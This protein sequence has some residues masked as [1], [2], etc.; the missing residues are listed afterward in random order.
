MDL[1]GTPIYTQEDNIIIVLI[2]KHGTSQWTTI[3]A[4][5]K[6]LTSTPR[7]SKQIRERYTKPHSDGTTNSPPTFSKPPGL[8]KKKPNSSKPILSLEANGKKSQLS[9]QEELTTP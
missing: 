8:L 9:S 5:M 3:A 4:E 7:S 2:Q 6:N 1:R